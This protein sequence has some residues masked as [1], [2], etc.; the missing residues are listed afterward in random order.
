[1]Q[2]LHIVVLFNPMRLFLPLSILAAGAG[3]IWGLPLLLAGLGLSTGA[4][5][6]LMT[7]LIL[8]VLGLVAEQL[9]LIRKQ[10]LLGADPDAEAEDMDVAAE[11]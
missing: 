3:L 10:S 7:G 11:E 9:S 1:M 4:L 2:L 8:F 5:L 6:G